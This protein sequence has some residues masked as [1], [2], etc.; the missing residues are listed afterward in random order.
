MRTRSA[1]AALLLTV[2]GALAHTAHAT[3]IRESFET[4][5]GPWT[6]DSYLAPGASQ[7]FNPAWTRT[8]DRALDGLWSLDMSASGANADGSLWLERTVDLP[9]GT[10]NIVL[11]FFLWSP[12]AAE[13]DNWEVLAH[14]NTFDAELESDLTALGETN[15]GEGWIYYE[16]DRTLALDA[17]ATVHAAFGL[18]VVAPGDRSY[19]FDDVAIT[20]VPAPGVAAMGVLGLG[21]L[22]RR[23]RR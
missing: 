6:T 18:N 15:R 17:P 8:T 1:L 19:G 3:T 22:T 7:P 21:V 10:W 23:R 2:A 9:A 13:V 16:L 5:L 4:G 12:V 14:V 11:S 20:I